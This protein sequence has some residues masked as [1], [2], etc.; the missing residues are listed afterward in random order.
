[1]QKHPEITRERIRLFAEKSLRRLVYPRRAPVTLT[2]YAAPGRI[3]YAEAVRGDYHP[4]RVGDILGPAWSTHWF[5]VE[6]AIRHGALQPLQKGGSG[7][8]VRARRE[9]R[10]RPVG[11]LR[12]RGELNTETRRQG[13]ER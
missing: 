1:M 3:S 13:E 9:R 11:R 10:R 8:R 12:R 4:V 6:A 5:R 7:G 2:A